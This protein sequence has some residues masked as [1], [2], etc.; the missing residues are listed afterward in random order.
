MK[1]QAL[2][3]IIGAGPLGLELAIALKRE[4]ISYL[5]FDQGQ[6]AQSIYNFPLQTHFFSSTERISIAGIP[7]QTYDQQK[8]SR[9]AYLAYIRTVALTHGLEVKTYEKVV[10]IISEKPEGFHIKTLFRDQ[11]HQYFVR[12]IVLATGST[13]FPRRL[14][15]PGEDLENVSNKME[16][17]HRYFQKNVV[18]IGGR[19]SAV[20]T[21]LRC[22]HAGA[23][24][25]LLVRETQLNPDSIK[26]WLYPE[27]ESR[28]RKK[29][30]ECFF[31]SQVVEIF[32][33]RV[34]ATNKDGNLFEIPADFIIKAIGFEA[35]L[36]LCHR[37]GMEISKEGKPLYNENSMET[38]VPGAFVLGTIV[39]GTQKRY[40]V[41]IENTHAHVEKIVNTVMSKCGIQHSSHSEPMILRQKPFDNLEE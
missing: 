7:I 30:I 19:N 35:D 38:S 26:Y 3:G 36:H 8:C 37:I 10:D 22:Y 15:V 32:P 34:C 20:E 16:D 6:M 4:G 27:I 29:E 41:F 28:I 33:N 1:T 23:H 2:V 14:E 40:L 17:P 13:S 9:E 5:Q 24:A 12:F 31:Q 21:A 11:E 39:G 25:T 18:V